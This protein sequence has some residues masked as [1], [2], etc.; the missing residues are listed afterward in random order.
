M[1]RRIL[2]LLAVLCLTI[3]AVPFVLPVM[4]DTGATA[5]A[6]DTFGLGGGNTLTVDKY[7]K[8]QIP[9]SLPTETNL[10]SVDNLT[11][12]GV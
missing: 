10:L 8:E 4:A 5:N 2:A 6:Q 3:S 1:R 11:A 12:N 7:T 9:T